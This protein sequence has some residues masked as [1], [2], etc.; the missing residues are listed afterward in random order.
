[1]NAAAPLRLL[2]IEDDATFARLVSR[3]LLRHG[4]ETVHADG[5]EEGLRLLG[6]GGFDA[7]ALDHIMP[8]MGG[9][10]T[11]EAIAAT[12]LSPPPIIYVTGADEGRVAVAALKAGAA[13]YV[14]KDAGDSFFELLARTIRQ[15]VEASDARRQRTEALAE[16]QAARERAE[17]L[18]REV[19]H[20]VAN[21][22]ALV[23]SLAHMQAQALGDSDA[24]AALIAIQ[25]RVTAI[26]QVHR[27][28]Y[29]SDD[30]RVVALDAYLSGLAEELRQSLS[31]EGV[32][33]RLELHAD[34]LETPT[35][36]AITL[37]I[38]VSELVTN[39]CKYA[40]RGREP[41]DVRVRLAR[42]ED[43]RAELSVEDDGVGL[44]VDA[45]IRSDGTGL[46][47][48]ILKTMARSLHSTLAYEDVPAGT[49][50]RMVFTP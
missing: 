4:I 44:P 2:Y 21:S 28:L 10:E 23:S 48:R 24:R 19:N 14:L 1:M 43:G 38:I 12:I 40:Y 13:D 26:A 39:A 18:L 47:G 41:D 45:A 50:A 3:A 42:L 31:D 36:K 33:G 49:R 7:V 9:P 46:G 25:N 8:T 30:V 32:L 34:F 17:L 29:T 5:G 6:G 27:R 35:D 20:R 37:G 16:A 22:L 11:L 15:A